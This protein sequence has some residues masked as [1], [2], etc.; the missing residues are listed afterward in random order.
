M[1]MGL[2]EM[3]KVVAMALQAWPCG[4]PDAAKVA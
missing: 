1:G 3:R 2:A 4:C